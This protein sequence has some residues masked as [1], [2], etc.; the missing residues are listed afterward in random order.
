MPNSFTGYLLE[1]PSSPFSQGL[2]LRSFQVV[3]LNYPSQPLGLRSS[4]SV[5]ANLSALK[6]GLKLQI[7]RRLW[8]NGKF[9]M[10]INFVGGEALGVLKAPMAAKDWKEVMD[11]INATFPNEVSRIW[12]QCRN[13]I[14]K[15]R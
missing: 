15:M 2:K 4:L 9:H 13:K 7:D 14:T 10:M 8:I 12:K 3:N 11:K 5:N 1:R 6:L